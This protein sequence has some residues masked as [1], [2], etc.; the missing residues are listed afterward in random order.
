MTKHSRPP[1]MLRVWTE[2]GA[3]R[4]H[5][6]Y[7]LDK[8]RVTEGITYF[9]NGNITINPS[10]G[11]ALSAQLTVAC[12]AVEAGAWYVREIGR[13]GAVYIVERDEAKVVTVRPG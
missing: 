4:I 8:G 12:R 2:L 3:G 9:S 13:Q 10:A 1:L 7:L 6:G 11:A 5:E